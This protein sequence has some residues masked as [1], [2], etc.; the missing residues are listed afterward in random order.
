MS[1]ATAAQVDEQRMHDMQSRINHMHQRINAI[2][3]ITPKTVRASIAAHQGWAQDDPE[4]WHGHV[5]AVR[6]D[7]LKAIADGHCDPAGLAAAVLEADAIP[8]AWTACA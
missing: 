4:T 6:R 2:N 3:A 5:D 7:V 8:V 1:D